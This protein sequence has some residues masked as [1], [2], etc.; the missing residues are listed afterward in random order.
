M[1]FPPH[2]KF[3][4]YHGEGTFFTRPCSCEHIAK[5]RDDQTKKIKEIINYRIL[6]Y[7]ECNKD[8]QCLAKA[9][10]GKTYIEDIEY[11]FGGN[12]GHIGY[13]LHK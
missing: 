7:S 8:D 11:H 10:A 6:D 9:D 12:N 5:I 1:N 13:S 3:C 2:D 4:E